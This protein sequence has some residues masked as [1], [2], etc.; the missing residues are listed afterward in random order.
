MV[1]YD[2]GRI[3]A[4]RL[5]DHVLVTRSQHIPRIQEAQASAWHVLRELR[6]GRG[7]SSFARARVRARVEGVVQGV[8]FRPFVHRLAG[9]HGLAGW[10]RN[11]GRGVLLE[12]EGDRTALERFLRSAWPG[13]APPLA[14]V[15]RVRAR[16][17]A[18]RPASRAFRSSRSDRTRR[19]AARTVVPRRRALRA[20]AWRSCSIPTTAATAIRS[21]T[22]P[23]CGPR[24]TIVRGV[25]YDRPLTTMAA[26]E[27][28]AAC[29]A[30]YED[31]ASRRFHAQPNACPACGPSLRL[32]DRAGAAI[33]AEDPVA[34][35][36]AR[37]RAPGG[38]SRSRASAATTSRAAPTTSAPS[39]SCD[40]RKRREE[41]PFAL[42][43]PDAEAAG[44]LVALSAAEARA[45]RAA[46]SGRS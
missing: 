29:R 14:A 3:A 34:A 8:G 6:R 16:A 45:R 32:V 7:V 39:P 26:F 31:P 27:M 40:A 38:S 17:A 20:T 33:P 36:A 46:A 43:A 35:A 11:D 15:E 23:N 42:M 44:E 24:F 1:G 37:A 2:G 9:E 30:E 12:V 41:K 21:S 22:A 25:P 19:P 28:C 18:P 13:E 4:E 10:V 5:A